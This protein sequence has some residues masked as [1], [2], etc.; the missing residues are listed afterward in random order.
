MRRIK[1][2]DRSTNYIV[3][4]VSKEDSESMD[5]KVADL[6]ERLEEKPKSRYVLEGSGK[7]NQMHAA[8]PI[9]FRSQ[10]SSTVA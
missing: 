8:R 6:L 4:G 5:F 10:S 3:Y 2:E 1:K 9:S 7:A